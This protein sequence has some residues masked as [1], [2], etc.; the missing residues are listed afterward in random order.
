MKKYSCHCKRCGNLFTQNVQKGVDNGCV[1][2]IVRRVQRVY[3]AITTSCC[4]ELPPR[5]YLSPTKMCAYVMHSL[6]LS[7]YAARFTLLILHMN[8]IC[9]RFILFAGMRLNHL[10]VLRVMT[11]CNKLRC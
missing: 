11:V 3:S 8:Q 2:L 5:F 6:T 7:M 1:F 9:D 4:S 10:V